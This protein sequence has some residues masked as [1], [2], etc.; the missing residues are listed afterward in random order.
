MAFI[1]QVFTA[2]GNILFPTNHVSGFQLVQARRP[3][4][5]RDVAIAKNKRVKL[6]F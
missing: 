3:S 1:Y 2:N 6:D 4:E 5:K